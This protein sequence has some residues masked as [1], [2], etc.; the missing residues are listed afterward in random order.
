MMTDPSQT[1]TSTND[2]N[3]N[4]QASVTAGDTANAVSDPSGPALV[5][6]DFSSGAPVSSTSDHA[7]LDQA[8]GPAD[9]PKSTTNKRVARSN[10]RGSATATLL[11]IAERFDLF[12]S[13]DGT[14]FADI[15]IDS[16]RETLA[17]HSKEFKDRLE[18]DYFR[19]V[20][21]APPRDAVQSAISTLKSRAKYEGP[22][23][24]VHVRIAGQEGRWFLDLADRERRAIQITTEGWS[25]IHNPPVHFL[26][27]GGMLALP[28]PERGGSIDNLKPFLNLR[29]QNDFVLVAAWL[30]AALR[31]RGPYPVLAVS[32]EHGSAKSSLSRLLR[33]L[34]DPNVAPLRPIP[35]SSRDFFIMAKNGHVMALDNLSGIPNWA[36]DALCQAA[37]GGGFATRKLHTD[38]EEIL[39]YVTRPI[40]LNGI[41]EI[42]GR[43]DLADRAISVVL[44]HITSPQP[45]EDLSNE[46]ERA[47]S[48]ILGALLDGVAH[49]QRTLP[50]VRLNEYPRMADFAKFATACEGAYW[51]PGTFST[52]YSANR[53][54][55]VDKMVE[56]DSLA[57]ALK[58]LLSMRTEWVG[59]ATDLLGIITNNAGSL[60]HDRDLPKS[61]ALL[62]KHLARSTPLLREIGINIFRDRVK[63]AG[64]RQ[65]KITKA[66]ST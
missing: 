62:S 6:H 36:S 33:S 8:S 21:D 10:R 23:H 13:A 17:L 49:G 42:M 11:S 48:R 63:H 34:I 25:I 51:S 28:V 5:Q 37:T 14:D 2:V 56:V 41:E 1:E 40:I 24:P 60:I 64:D 29:D 55:A 12:H 53:A 58:D 43:P 30:T 35:K 32:G 16:H 7:V 44:E 57:S 45:E 9:E 54:H 50:Q 47:Q 22:E 31:P 39:V 3:V 46:F 19:E 66:N 38:G 4:H 26:R 52:A 20:K 27:P 18:Y 15:D 59:T 65:I 61:P